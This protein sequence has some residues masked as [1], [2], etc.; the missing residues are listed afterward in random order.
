M[1]PNDEELFRR[2][3]SN[4]NMWRDHST[5]QISSA[6]FKDSQGCSV[7]RKGNRDSNEIVMMFSQRFTD[8]DA[9]AVVTVQNCTEVEAIVL[10]KPEPDNEYHCEIHRDV[11]TA[12]LTKGQLK[13]LVE[14]VHVIMINK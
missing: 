14:K 4:P 9:V 5:G 10:E 1:L 3:P 8:I 2:I 13:R 6:A 7:D 11:N 12:Q